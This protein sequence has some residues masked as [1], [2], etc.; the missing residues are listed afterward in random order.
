ML[1]TLIYI[2]TV[3]IWGTTWVAIAYQVGE[4]PISIS[5]MYR[6]GI[7]ALLL[8]LGLGLFGK[9]QR[10]SFKQHLSCLAIGML[11][12][13]CNFMLFYHAAL[14]IPSGLISIVFSLAT[15]MNLLNLR[16]FQG[17]TISRSAGFGAMLGVLGLSAMFYPQISQSSQPSEIFVGLGLALAGTYCFSIGNLLSAK[18]QQ[19]GLSVLS[20]NAYGMAYGTILLA[21][22]S[23]LT[24]ASFSL[25]LEQQYF[26]SLL[27]LAIIGSVVG[28]SLY[29]SLVGRIG[30]AK[31]AYCTV[32]F[33]V[34][35]LGISSLLEGYQWSP[36]AILGLISVLLGNLLVFMPQRWF[37]A[38]H[39]PTL[40]KGAA[41]PRD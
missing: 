18:Q 19:S 14:T 23:Y 22:W 41:S 21:L 12:F 15:V 20:V 2:F 31:A 4:V 39:L 40:I 32:M 25:H 8:L 11:L 7:A 26:A 34:V 33:P 27:Y 29:L 24:G 1:T 5:I 3:I 38:F 28:F 17:Q 13:S 36:I 10:I 16:V 35:A 37:K 9:L 30:A 6:F